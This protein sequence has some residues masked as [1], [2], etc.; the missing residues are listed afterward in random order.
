MI[1]YNTPIVPPGCVLYNQTAMRRIYS[2]L[3]FWLLLS[4]FSLPVFA[5]GEFSTTY[6]LIYEVLE[7]GETLVTYNV[8]L[9]N[10]TEN[11]YASEYT[12]TFGGGQIENI[13]AFDDEGPILQKVIRGEG[14]TTVYLVFNK[15]V[16]G[17]GKTINWRLSFVARDIAVKKGLVWEVKTPRL[18]KGVEIDKY[19]LTLIVPLSFR[20]PLYIFPQPSSQKVSAGKQYFY[21]QKEQLKNFG[22]SAVF[23]KYQV[24]S[25]ELNYHLFNPTFSPTT[26]KIP[27]PP[28]TSY[29]TIL[30]EEIDPR[31]ANVEIDFDG[32]YLALY[33]LQPNQ[34]LDI[35]VRG[36]AKIFAQSKSSFPQ[37]LSLEQKRRFLRA[38]K[39]WERDNL[40]IKNLAEKLQTPEAIYNFV[41]E[42]LSYSRER[43]RRGE[44]ERKGAV[45]ALQTPDDSLCMEFTDLFVA[46]CRAAGIPARSLSG[47][48]YSEK[49]ESKPLGLSLKDK[50]ILHSWAEYYDEKKGWTPVDPTWENTTGGI[51]FF[52]KFDLSHFVFVIHGSSSEKPYP[53]GSYKLDSS[54]E[55]DVKVHLANQVP[56]LNLE[57]EIEAQFPSSVISGLPFWGKVILKQKG[58]GT[59]FPTDLK[60]E[61]RFFQILSS[62]SYSLPPLPPFSKK[63]FQVQLKS[64]KVNKSRM[65]SIIVYFDGDPYTFQVLVRPFLVSLFPRILPFLGLIVF[66]SFILW[67][68]FH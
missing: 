7:T 9:T 21:F 43:L 5:K 26:Y 65:E 64:P 32:N 59:Y 15:K 61:S 24:F 53:P 67:R 45:A 49:E 13:Q 40:M 11:Y 12:L 17:R 14:K 29:Q 54:R 60:I 30:F 44:V 35:K 46:L 27:I 38:Q 8:S 22:I 68:R 10:K 47:F 52:H 34:K 1:N 19:T 62:S 36:Y 16:A 3:L 57:T 51:D 28:D 6:D 63:E 50:D 20:H 55:P 37:K 2:G 48:A 42:T 25:F 41:V 23:G 4:I 33:L 66:F 39:Y 18:G 31:P 56:Q 58:N